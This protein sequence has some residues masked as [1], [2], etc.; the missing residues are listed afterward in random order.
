MVEIRIEQDCSAD[1]RVSRY[2]VVSSRVK[3]WSGLDLRAEVGRGS[4]QE[5]VVGVSAD[6]E[7]R[8]GSSF[9]VEGSGSKRTAVGADA[10]P[11]GE[12]SSS[13]RTENLD[14]H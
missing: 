14:L 9:S 13:G 4:E 3:L 11:L 6:G 1:R 2:A 5:P 7:L 12:A 8:L 10:I